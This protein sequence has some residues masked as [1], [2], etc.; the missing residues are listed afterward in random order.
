MSVPPEKVQQEIADAFS[1][2]HSTLRVTE[3]ISTDD[4]NIDEIDIGFEIGNDDD[5][6]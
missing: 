4:S 6:Q 2:S 1:A 5:S 3:G